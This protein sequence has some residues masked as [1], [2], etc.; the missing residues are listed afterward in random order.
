MDHTFCDFNES[1]DFWKQRAQTEIEYRY[2]WSQVGFFKALLPMK[3]AIDFWNEFYDKSSL[4]FLTRP[5]LPNMHCYSEKAEWIRKYL[6]QEGLERLI[7]SPRKDLLIGDY[8]IDDAENCGQQT[9]KGEWWKFG[10]ENYKD[11]SVISRKMREIY[12]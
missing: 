7:L 10:S 3:G 2:P 9:F 1:L 4:W 5:S 11:W 6:G 8:L 12:F